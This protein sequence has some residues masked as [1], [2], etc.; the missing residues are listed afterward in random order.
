[1]FFLGGKPHLCAQAVA[2]LR[3]RYPKLCI[4]GHY[5][6]PFRPLSELPHEEIRRQILAAQ[7]DIV[8]VS[9]GCPKAEKWMAMHYQSLGVPV[10]IG[11]GGP[12]D[13]LTGSRTRAPGWA[14]RSGL[15][16]R[17]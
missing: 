3:H 11:V 2:N 14:L 13:S 12:I 4:A 15:G 5:S 9:F 17:L 16:W 10:L 8:F 7:P 1:L 6:P